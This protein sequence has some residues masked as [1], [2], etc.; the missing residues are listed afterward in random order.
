M[1]YVLVIFSC[2]SCKSDHHKSLI[3]I[4]M[5]Y[6]SCKVCSFFLLILQYFVLHPLQPPTFLL[7]ICFV[8]SISVYDFT[9][10]FFTVKFNAYEVFIRFSTKYL[11][12]RISLLKT[13]YFV[14]CHFG[15]YSYSFIHLIISL[16]S[17]QNCCHSLSL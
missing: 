2:N 10:P 17:L 1:L 5:Q 11:F 8:I 9:I 4:N 15:Y 6:V 13:R 12:N 3:Y 16:I 7:L 14:F